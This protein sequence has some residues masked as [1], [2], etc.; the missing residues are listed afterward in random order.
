MVGYLTTTFITNL[1]SGLVAKI[2]WARVKWH[3]GCL[4]VFFFVS[5]CKYW[6]ECERYNARCTSNAQ[7]VPKIKSHAVGMSSCCDAGRWS[8]Q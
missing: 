3:L 5:S 2:T 8:Q 7:P 6:S 1:L 4:T